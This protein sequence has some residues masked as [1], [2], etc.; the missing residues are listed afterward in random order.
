M[1]ELK[2]FNGFAWSPKLQK[3]EKFQLELKITEV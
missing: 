3:G 2:S 1:D